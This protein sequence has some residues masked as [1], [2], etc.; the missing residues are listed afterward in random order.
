MPVQQCRQERT[1][2]R[3]EPHLLAAELAFQHCDLV[4]KNKYL[5]VLV[6]IAHGQQAEHRKRVRYA[7]VGQS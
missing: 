5:E 1:I 4:A 2:S 7:Q 3:S 6:L